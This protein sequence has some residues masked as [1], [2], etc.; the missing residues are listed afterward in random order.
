MGRVIVAS[1]SPCPFFDM[2]FLALPRKMQPA[3]YSNITFHGHGIMWKLFLL[4]YCMMQESSLHKEM[5]HDKHS[6]GDPTSP[7]SRIRTCKVLIERNAM[8]GIQTK[9]SKLN[10]YLREKITWIANRNIC[11]GNKRHNKQNT[12]PVRAHTQLNNNNKN[13]RFHLL[14][15][16][17]CVNAIYCVSTI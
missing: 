15:K 12:I 16:C 11:F 10:I 5:S 3:I 1:R 7:H 6:E 4:L 8:L 9:M 14:S 13:G 17:A 2:R